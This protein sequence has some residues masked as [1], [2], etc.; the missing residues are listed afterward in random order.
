MVIFSIV[1][2][3]TSVVSICVIFPTNQT[4]GSSESIFKVIVDKFNSKIDFAIFCNDGNGKVVK[5]SQ[6]TIFLRL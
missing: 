1:T 3:L 6:L 5:H 4:R 2:S